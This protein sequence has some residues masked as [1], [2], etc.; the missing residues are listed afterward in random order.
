M[1]TNGKDPSLKP[2]LPVNAVDTLCVVFV[3][4]GRKPEESTQTLHQQWARD[5]GLRYQNPEFIF[6]FYQK[7]FYS[8]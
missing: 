8:L 7:V 5:L 1:S 3:H 4:P 6:K 2:V